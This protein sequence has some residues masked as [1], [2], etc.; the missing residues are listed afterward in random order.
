MPWVRFVD[1]SPIHRKV[2]ALLDNA[3]CDAVK[4]TVQQIADV[5]AVPRSSAAAPPPSC[6]ATSGAGSS[7]A[8][9]TPPP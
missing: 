9:S 6:A 3:P 8:T 1:Q 2:G 5:D 7:A 4:A